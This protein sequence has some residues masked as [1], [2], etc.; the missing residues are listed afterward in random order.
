MEGKI[1]DLGDAI[2]VLKQS[3]A[4]PVIIQERVQELLQLKLELD[5][6]TASI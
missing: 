4:E 6:L 1:Q 2:R 5:M 3:K